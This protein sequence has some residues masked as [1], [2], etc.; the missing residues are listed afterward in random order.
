MFTLGSGMFPPELGNVWLFLAVGSCSAM[1]F[2][3]SKSG[4]GAGAG[5]LSVPMMIYACGQN[6]PLAVGVMLPVLIAADYAAVIAWRGHWTLRQVG[7]LLP[8]VIVGIAL[9]AS[10]V[11]AFGQ[12]EA[13]TQ[14]DVTNAG[15]KLGVGIIALGFVALRLISHLRGQPLAFRPVWWQA[16]TAGA[17]AGVAST[18]AHAA[19]P[20][21]AMYLLPQQMP[22]GRY[23]ATTALTFWCVNQLK[24]PAYFALGLVNTG[25]LGMGLALL[26]GIAAG[27]ALGVYLHRKVGD[28]QFTPIVYALLALAGMHL[29]WRALG[30]LWP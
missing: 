1:L 6:A 29:T 4:F 7:M 25:T 27:A 16:A 21:V 13:D 10:A 15:L 12:L 2:S 18:L 11:W 20:V 22:K 26:P 9:G 3:M 19:G 8:G 24:L 5:I 23:V 14:A 28:K 30:A 17:T